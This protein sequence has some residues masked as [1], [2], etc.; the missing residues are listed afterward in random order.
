M[1]TNDQW[2]TTHHKTQHDISGTPE[3]NMIHDPSFNI[4]QFQE[5]NEIEVD[6]EVEVNEVYDNVKVKS[7]NKKRRIYFTPQE[8]GKEEAEKEER[9]R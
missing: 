3:P 5:K 8:K 4:L 2:Q 9:R 6:V 1:L 7:P